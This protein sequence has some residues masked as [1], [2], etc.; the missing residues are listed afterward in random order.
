MAIGLG[1]VLIALGAV[2]VFDAVT[3]DL[4]GVND[5]ALGG[6]LLAA[7]IL[8]IVLSLI[9]NAQRSRRTIVEERR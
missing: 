2:L 8:A 6:V 3:I 1:V 7:G 5:H 4:S 9:V